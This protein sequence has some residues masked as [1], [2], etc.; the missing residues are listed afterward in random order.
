MQFHKAEKFITEF[1]QSELSPSICYHDYFHTMDV[2]NATVEL[3][4]EENITDENDLILLK[5]AALFHDCG[6]VNVYANHEEEGCRIAKKILPRFGYSE[7]QVSIICKIIMK[8]K[9]PSQPQTHLE[10]ILCDADL[11]YLGRDDFGLLGKKLFEE[12]LAKGKVKNEQEWNEMQIKFLESH[13]YCTRSAIAK[14]GRKK[15]EHLKEL[16]AKV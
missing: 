9:L 3:A 12:W 16:K 4:K 10:K 11:D 14:R 2:L 5:T 15:A 7:E 6:F 1:L 8:T 13:H